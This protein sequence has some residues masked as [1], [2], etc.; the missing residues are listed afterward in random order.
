MLGDVCEISV[1]NITKPHYRLQAR[2]KRSKGTNIIVTPR[3]ICPATD[4]RRTI[5]L[6]QLSIFDDTIVL[7][8][9]IVKHGMIKIAHILV[10]PF[11]SPP[12]GKPAKMNGK[13]CLV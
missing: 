9:R 8:H 6:K 7:R 4:S 11:K 13:P 2:K 10:S 12:H 3:P 5:L 1:A